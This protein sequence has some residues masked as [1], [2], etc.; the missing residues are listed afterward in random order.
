[1]GFVWG[2]AAVGLRWAV[3]PWITTPKG[4]RGA[5]P[6][7]EPRALVDK[8]QVNSRKVVTRDLDTGKNQRSA[9]SQRCRL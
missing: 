5:S 8:F 9:A 3:V 7:A 1:M 4:D 6:D 2:V